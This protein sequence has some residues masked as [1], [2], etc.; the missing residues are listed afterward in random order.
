MQQRLLVGGEV[1]IH[2]Q[3][4]RE[5]HQRNQ[6]GRLHLRVDVLLRSLYSAIGIVIL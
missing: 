1:L 4:S 5:A 3:G 2:A 6:V